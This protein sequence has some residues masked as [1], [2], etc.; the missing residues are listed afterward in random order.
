[1]KHMCAFKKVSNHPLNRTDLRIRG[2]ENLGTAEK[3]KTDKNCWWFPPLA[4]ENTFQC[5][6]GRNPDG[7]NDKETIQHSNSINY[8]ISNW[9][10]I[11]C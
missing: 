11:L 9:I 8:I 1:M 10:H 6:T 4:L 2:E 5:V 7:Q 3:I